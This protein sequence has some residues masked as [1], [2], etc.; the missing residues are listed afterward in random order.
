MSTKSYC[1][2]LRLFQTFNNVLEYPCGLDLF[3]LLHVYHILGGMTKLLAIFIDFTVNALLVFVQGCC[4]SLW[5]LDSV[6]GFWHCWTAIG[7]CSLALL[8]VWTVVWPPLFLPV[9]PFTASPTEFHLCNC[10]F[11]LY[12]S[13]LL[14]LESVLLI[15]TP[16]NQIATTCHEPWHLNILNTHIPS[17]Q[18]S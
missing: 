16:V 14:P 1:C 10:A 7:G 2:A 18:I 9:L 17:L 8:G 11:Q 6:I 13:V 5:I 4:W 15:E 3:T 12:L